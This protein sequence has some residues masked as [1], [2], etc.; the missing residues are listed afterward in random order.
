MARIFEG[1]H[2]G[3]GLRIAVVVARFNAPI[4]EKLL[5]GAI[6]TARSRGVAEDDVIVAWV[7][8]AFEIPLIGARL[9]ERD[10]VDAVVGLGCVIRG[11]TS[12][13]DFV[14]H[15][16]TVGTLEAGLQSRKPFLFGVLTVEDREQALAR[17]GGKKTNKGVEVM[18]A[19]IELVRLQESLDGD[20]SS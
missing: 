11:E 1:H 17:A 8:G 15:G 3:K 7:P 10:D 16:V 19:A 6:E 13:F 5:E 18:D 9:L 2:D 12:H 4:T 20:P 14:S